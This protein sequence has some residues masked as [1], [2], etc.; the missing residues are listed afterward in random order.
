MSKKLKTEEN[1]KISPHVS[2]KEPYCA[3]WKED[4]LFEF[5][6]ITDKKDYS[7]NVLLNSDDRKALQ[8]YFELLSAISEATWEELKI[9]SKKIKGGYEMLEYSNFNT[10]IANKYNSNMSLDT[11]LLVFRFGK[12][13]AYRMIGYK[14]H[15]C[16]RVIHVLGFDLDFSLYDHGK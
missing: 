6:H 8:S 10:L 3:Q 2:L 4:I 16:S 15:N 12:G 9:R 13:D 5:G 7:L 1:N 14:S 11:K